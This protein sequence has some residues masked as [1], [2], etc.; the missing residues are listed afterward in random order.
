MEPYI[1]QAKVCDV[2]YSHGVIVAE[3]LLRIVSDTKQTEEER[4]IE[5]V[6][7]GVK[8]IRL[9]AIYVFRYS[10]KLGTYNLLG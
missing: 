4:Y 8:D 9:D 6:W 2:D 7:S 5:A 10:D 3:K 1:V